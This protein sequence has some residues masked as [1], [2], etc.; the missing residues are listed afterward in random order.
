MVIGFSKFTGERLLYS[1][2]IANVAASGIAAGV[3]LLGNG[4]VVQA[5]SL[6]SAPAQLLHRPWS[7]VTY[8]FVQGGVM[9][10]L[11]NML[12][13]YCFGRILL[14]VRAASLLPA[15]YLG[16]G[17]CGAICFLALYAA[18]PSLRTATLLGSSAAVIAVA[19]AV[20]FEVPDMRLNVW[21]LGLVRVKW[22]VLAMVALFCVG[23]TG[24]MAGNAAHF[25]GAV[26]GGAVGARR[27]YSVASV[28]RSQSIGQMRQ[29]L[30]VLLDKVKVSGY[31]ALSARDKRRLFELSHKLRH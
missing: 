31:E 23:L 6:P 22:I 19:V 26:F 4:H 30:D 25:G 5:L 10:L 16:G 14:N 13:L 11:F 8:M 2:I 28:R 20:A 21:P 29:E 1:L 18:V 17:V 27:Y 9:H 12:W 24:S 7:I 15:V 3:D